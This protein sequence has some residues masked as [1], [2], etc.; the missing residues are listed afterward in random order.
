MAL[1]NKNIG[2]NRKQDILRTSCAKA[3]WQKWGLSIQ[4]PFYRPI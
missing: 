1:M 4:G 3:L 2:G